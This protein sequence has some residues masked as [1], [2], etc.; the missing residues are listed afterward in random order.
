MSIYLMP[1]QP[2]SGTFWIACYICCTSRKEFG[3]SNKYK[4]EKPK[5]NKCGK[6]ASIIEFRPFDPDADVD[7]T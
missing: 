3:F 5:C 6:E 2:E 1:P 4:S 7:A